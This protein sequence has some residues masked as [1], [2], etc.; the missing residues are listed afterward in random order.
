[1][2]QYR[3]VYFTGFPTKKPDCKAKEKGKDNLVEQKAPQGGTG[4][5][6]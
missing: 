5:G 4:I 3:T 2:E 6:R 1:M